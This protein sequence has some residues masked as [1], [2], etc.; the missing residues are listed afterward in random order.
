MKKFICC[1]FCALFFFSASNSFSTGSHCLSPRSIFS[2]VESFEEPTPRI[3]ESA[4][5]KELPFPNRL[6][7]C[8]T[9]QLLEV[10]EL[11]Q[12]ASL[13][14]NVIN[15]L[16][17]GKRRPTPRIVDALVSALGVSRELLFPSFIIDPTRGEAFRKARE[18][19]KLT[20]VELAK[21]AGVP[22]LTV[23]EFEVNGLVPPRAMVLK[24]AHA[25][26]IS[27][28]IPVKEANVIEKEESVGERIERI[29]ESRNITLKRLSEIAGVPHSTLWNMRQGSKLVDH[30]NLARIATALGVTFE[31]LSPLPSLNDLNGISLGK[32]LALL[33]IARGYSRRELGKK[34]GLPEHT[35][36]G[37]E[38]VLVHF[39]DANREKLAAALELPEA[40]WAV[41]VGPVSLNGS[42]EVELS[43]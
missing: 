20:R 4:E 34:V 28:E 32:Q 36:S 17:R 35:I 31:E 19:K 25:L 13:S 39:S 41:F 11:A 7:V 12:K 2:V 33:R 29:R 15:N 23:Q 37:Y 5:L 14:V 22:Y 6:K 16:E 8:R 10:E 27:I 40:Y 26:D 43:L 24:L 21:L 1:L 3:P 30:D 42:R 9:A 38:K 18:E